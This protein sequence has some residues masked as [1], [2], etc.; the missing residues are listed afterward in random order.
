MVAGVWVD[1]SSSAAERALNA[2]RARL[3]S[4]PSFQ[5]S[6]DPPPPTP[7]AP[8]WLRWIGKLLSSVL[9]YM[10]WLLWAA[11]IIGVVVILALIGR[12]IFAK[13]SGRKTARTP[14]APAPADWRPDAVRARTL[15]SDAD[16]LA[17]EGRFA[18][19]ARLL[20][21]RSIEDIEDRRP[22]RLATAYTSRDIAALE[23]LPEPA[24][25]AFGRMAGHVEHSLFGDQRLD[26]AAFGE[27]RAAY[28]DFAFPE[29][30]TRP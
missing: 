13:R 23:W 15:L 22:H 3:L 12:E 17:S 19:A 7:Q 25:Q 4:D 8:A 18:E 1:A 21:H 27:C 9:P 5:F 11:L 14:A 6:F 26:A 2:A 28:A 10:G 30:W 29:T 16:R 24:R 20:L